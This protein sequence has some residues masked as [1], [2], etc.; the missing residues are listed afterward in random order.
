MG[1]RPL[2]MG[3]TPYKQTHGQTQQS[4]HANTLCTVRYATY[5][6]G[7]GPRGG[8]LHRGRKGEDGENEKTFEGWHDGHASVASSRVE[9]DVLGIK[10]N[11]PVK[12]KP[13]SC[14]GERSACQNALGARKV[15]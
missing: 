6:M 9:M 5:D 8:G 15:G 3:A 14:M 12:E 10:G 13:H 1:S 4:A 11:G 7:L 2:S